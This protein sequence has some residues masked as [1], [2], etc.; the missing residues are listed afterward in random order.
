VTRPALVVGKYLG[1]AA[2]IVLALVPMLLFLLMAL[3]H[4][5]MST[6]A[7]DPD[8]PVLLFSFL[9]LGAALLVAVWCNYFYGTYFSQTFLT[10]L[11]PAMVVAYI[12]VLFVGKHWRI[13]PPFHD[14]KPQISAACVCLIAAVLVLTAIATAVSTRLGQVMTVVVC[15]GIFLF[16]LLSNYFV[17]RYAF[18][19]HW[20]AIVQGVSSDESSGVLGPGQYL[21][22]TLKNPPTRVIRTGDSFFYGPSPNGFPMAIAAFPRFAGDLSQ[23]NDVENSETAPGLVVSSVTGQSMK[24]RKVGTGPLPAYRLPRPTD[25]VF[26]EPTHINAAALV[27]W[28]VIPN[29]HVFWL[30]DAIS[31]NQHIPLSHFGLI[32]GYAATQIVVFLAVGVILFQK[33]DVG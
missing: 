13:Q 33:R 21:T 11:A 10:V 24:V 19:N 12:A 32:L 14:F 3:R 2:A 20:V 31:Q 22:V 28:G 7:D 1:V 6:A 29:M 4:G 18:Q 9:A 15:A 26:L 5:V 17:G 27:A 30:V 23:I 16:G 8:Q 25:Y